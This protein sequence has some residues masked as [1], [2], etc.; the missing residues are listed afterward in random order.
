MADRDALIGTAAGTVALAAGA[1]GAMEVQRRRHNAKALAG[2]SLPKQGSFEPVAKGPLSAAER[3]ALKTYSGYAYGMVNE[4]LRH[5]RATTI[6]EATGKLVDSPQNVEQIRRTISGI[7]SAFEKSAVGRA[8]L[9]RGVGLDR[10][11]DLTPG[12]V[13]ADKGVVSTST[14]PSEAAFFHD[15]ARKSGRKAAMMVIDARGARGIDM[16]EFSKF[17]HEAEVALAPGTQMRV[18][19]VAKGVR[20]SIFDLKGRDYAF[21]SV[22]NGEHGAA[23]A[24]Q[25]AARA[26]ADVSRFSGA[27][28]GGRAMPAPVP[29]EAIAAAM[30]QPAAGGVASTV[31]RVSAAATP[32]AAASVA[33]LAYRR[34]RDEG[35][36]EARAALEAAGAGAS[37]AVAPAVI[38]AAAAKLAKSSSIGA[39]ALGIA[40]RALLPVSVVGH[41]GAYAL[42]AI[43][44]GE[45]AADVAKA[46]GWGAVNGFIPVDL[47]MD[48]YGAVRGNGTGQSNPTTRSETSAA[49][50][51]QKAAE[52]KAADAAWRAKWGSKP[53]AAEKQGQGETRKG[54]ANPATQHAA[55][56]ARGVQQFS[57][58]AEPG[59]KTE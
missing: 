37:T 43:Q 10:I 7:N 55:Q 26:N 12:R 23:A 33:A 4:Y 2:R 42:A 13:I 58:W 40:S 56:A 59:S 54:W 30:R 8:T 17:A 16:R 1:A 6:N 31:A 51:D 50:P 19:H 53:G 47:A 24:S 34:A 22:V 52:F 57:D 46:A 15:H 25:A 35:K 14:L 38:G 3:G 45:G 18:D 39:K 20:S 29:Q 49:P 28:G 44:R 11:G 21:M 5:G 9:F 36:G 32:V 48:A 27:L 41:A